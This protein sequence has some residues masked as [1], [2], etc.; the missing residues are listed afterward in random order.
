MK[1][2]ASL[3]VAASALDIDRKVPPRHPTNRLA[4]LQSFCTAITEA[5]WIVPGKT[6]RF[7]KM[8]KKCISWANARDANFDKCGSY[9]PDLPNGGPDP[10]YV[11]KK[12]ADY[13]DNWD[14]GR[15]SFDDMFSNDR[16]RRSDDCSN[17]DGNTDDLK[18]FEWTDMIE[19]ETLTVQVKEPC[20][21]GYIHPDWVGDEYLDFVKQE[22]MDDCLEG[23]DDAENADSCEA[24]CKAITP[25]GKGGSRIK[26]VNGRGP[27]KTAK[28]IVS[29]IRKWEERYLAECHG[30]RSGRHMNKR[31]NFIRMVLRKFTPEFCSHEDCLKEGF[32]KNFKWGGK[33]LKT[34]V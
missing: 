22:M 27:F 5:D 26:R 32:A 15:V 31:H 25:R 23:C 20:A 12:A 10:N 7:T 24:K 3:I 30:H 17:W 4:R 8:A 18:Y 28:S 16:K 33:N 11:P 21:D 1:I 6:H 14:T 34:T 13:V 2:A 9:N 19:G 29:G